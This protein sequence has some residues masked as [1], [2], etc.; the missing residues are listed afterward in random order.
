MRINVLG[1]QERGFV[2]IL[3]MN[4]SSKLMTSEVLKGF[5]MLGARKFQEMLGVGLNV[6][7]LHLDAFYF[8]PDL[9]MASAGLVT[10]PNSC[11]CYITTSTHVY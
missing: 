5:K 2:F 3:N 7:V 10:R 1:V 11:F 6:I 4:R 9:Y 8:A